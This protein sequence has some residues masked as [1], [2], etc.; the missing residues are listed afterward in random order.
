M[1]DQKHVEMFKGEL[2]YI[3]DDE[4]LNGNKIV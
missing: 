1:I 4:I 3:L 2:K